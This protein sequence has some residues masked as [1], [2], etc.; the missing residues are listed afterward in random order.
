MIEPTLSNASSQN[1]WHM[2]HSKIFCIA[3]ILVILFSER[4]A[5]LPQPLLLAFIVISIAAI[6]VP[7]G[8]LDI[9]FAKQYWKLNT[10]FGWLVFLQLYLMLVALV[11]GCWLWQPTL[12]FI[13]F[14]TISIWH[15]ADDLPSSTPRMIKI[16]QG[17]A[18]IVLPT[19]IFNT[20]MTQLFSYFI[21]QNASLILIDKLRSIAL[22]W[23]LG[24]LVSA[25]WLSKRNQTAALEVIL[26]SFLATLVTPLVAFTLY[27]C[28]L[29]SVRHVLRSEAF[30]SPVTKTLKLT[31][32]IAPTV[33]TLF[34]AALCWHFLPAVTFNA[35]LIQ[36]IF[37]SLAALTL[38]H[39]I[40]LYVTG[41]A[42]WNKD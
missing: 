28:G 24:M 5:L 27:F 17:G 39:M 11:V 9:L 38:P 19:L 36:I 32:L 8:A 30:L 15:F 23:F 41:F 7:H 26:T 1:Q 3:A 33:V 25:L 21:N 40:I 22:L 20:E 35:K 10:A 13:G 12:F 37:V 16:L 2:R 29:H 31:G 18:L 34:I 42:V 6:G 14:L 4:I